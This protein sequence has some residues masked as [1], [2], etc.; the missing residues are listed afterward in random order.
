MGTAWIILRRSARRRLVKCTSELHL[1]KRLWV[2]RVRCLP[3]SV[4]QRRL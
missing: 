1:P 4:M 3:R 2:S